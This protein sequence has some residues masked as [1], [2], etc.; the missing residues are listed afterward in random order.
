VDRRRVLRTAGSGIG[1]AVLW[2]AA[3]HRAL[4]A[5]A[6]ATER[7][8][9]AIDGTPLCYWRWQDGTAGRRVERLTFAS[10]R[11]FHDRLVRWVRDLRTIAATYGGLHGMDRIVTAGVFV[12]K[13]GE[14]GLGNAF[15]LDQ[16]RWANGAITPYARE[17]ASPD[18]RTRRRYLALDAVCRRHFHWVLDGGYN[19]DHG[20]H[21]H[22][23]LGGGTIRCDK[24]SKSDPAFVQ[25]VL[26]AHQGARLAVDGAWGPATER[27]FAESCRRLGVTG[28]PGVQTDAWRHWLLRSAACGFANVPFTAPPAQITDPLAG[29]LDPLV[30]GARGALEELLGLLA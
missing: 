5:P 27:A 24:E 18:L 12:D 11:A 3:P 28:D 10:S 2:T 8:F 17:H 16:V 26:N 7:R 19:A 6:S 13:P 20:D 1:A 29:I 4:A 30:P 9:N 15:D 21:L 25:Q 22:M 23:D 14:H